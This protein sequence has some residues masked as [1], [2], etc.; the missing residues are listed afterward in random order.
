M[1]WDII[2]RVEEIIEKITGAGIYCVLAQIYMDDYPTLP[3][4]TVL[5]ADGINRINKCN[6]AGVCFNADDYNISLV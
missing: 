2:S 3:T 5:K 4:I 1:N 6:R